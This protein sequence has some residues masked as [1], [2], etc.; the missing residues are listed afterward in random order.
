MRVRYDGGHK[1]HSFVRY[2]L[3]R[4]VEFVPVCPEVEIGLGTPRETIRLEGDPLDPR[5]V[6]PRSGR[7]LTH[8]MKAYASRRLDELAR[9]GLH[10]YIL[11]KDSPSCGMKRVR[12]H[13]AR[14]GGAARVGTGLF[15]AALLSRFPSLPVEEEDRLNDPVRRD[16]FIE[17]VFAFYRLHALLQSGPRARDLVEFHS[18]SEMAVLAH[19]PKHYA[20]LEQL[21]ASAGQTPGA[22][23][24]TYGRLFMEAL[25]IKATRRKH[26]HVLQRL[27]GCL[28][29][30]L[31]AN[32]SAEIAVSIEEYRQGLVPL[33]VPLTLL[34]HHCR[35]H[36]IEWALKQTY[37]NPY[38]AELMLRSQV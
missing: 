1:E 29:R 18:R 15:A 27:A 16:N 37:L 12:V 10:G 24:Q 28:K 21:A 14:S 31:D 22:T 19:S 3:A 6:A 8:T 34:K 5:L 35:R 32:D 7:D 2:T 20:Q 38:P 25:K 23:L 11:K 26:T 36:S 4:Y 17:R 30:S 13:Q 9:T 33:V